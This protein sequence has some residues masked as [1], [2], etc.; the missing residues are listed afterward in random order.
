[1]THY[2][3]RGRTPRLASGRVHWENCTA[4]DTSD[5][6]Y[7]VGAIVP[8]IRASVDYGKLFAQD[9]SKAPRLFAARCKMYTKPPPWPPACRRLVAHIFAH[10]LSV[11]GIILSGKVKCTYTQKP[12]E[13]II[14]S[15]ILNLK[16]N[17]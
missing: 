2:C 7:A 3:V 10:K 11:F 13:L 1:M 17:S 12:T 16:I 5:A 4:Y 14:K 6:C 8:R 9:V 15:V